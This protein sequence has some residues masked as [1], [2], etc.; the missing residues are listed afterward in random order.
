MSN[1]MP[2]AQYYKGCEGF[3]RILAM[4]GTFRPADLS[5]VAFH[6]DTSAFN[7]YRHAVLSR[8]T[9]AALPAASNG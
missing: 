1:N 4:G 6:H 8:V 9:L 5:E 7:L 2:K 3:A